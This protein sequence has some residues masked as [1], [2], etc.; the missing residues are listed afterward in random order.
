[1]TMSHKR[2]LGI[3]VLTAAQQR[4]SR[5]FDDFTKVCV[6]FSGGKDSTVLTHLALAEAR[7]RKRKVGVLCVDLEAQYRMTVEHIEDVFASNREYIEPFWVALPLHLRNAVSQIE[8]FWLCWDPAA[9]ERWVREPHPD[10]ITDLDFF[11]F[12]RTG[13]EFEEFVP[14]FARWY[15]ADQKA[16]SLVGIRSDESLNRFRTIA[17]RSKTTHAGL[18][19]TT[20]ADD[21]IYSAFPIYDWRTEDIWTYCAKESVPYNKIYDYMH[22][23]GL[24]IHQQRLCQP[25][26]DDQRKGLWL[27][28]VLEPETWPKIVNRV[29]GANQ[30]ALY[31]RE[32]GSISG[33]GKV[34]KPE[35]LTWRD[36]S[37]LLLDSMPP[38]T[39]EHYK[40][41]IARFLKW[42]EAHGYPTGIPDA[43]PGKIS[44]KDPSWQ[45]I[46]KALLRN[47]YWSK[48]LGF[49]MTKSAAYERYLQVMRQRRSQWGLMI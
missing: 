42:Y 45:R 1:M 32:R 44:D 47:D 49:S 11:P 23:A 16:V 18:Q 8:P 26:G 3:D 30:G 10:S 28:H 19:W 46:C 14:A 22:Q 24:T 6:S 2:S 31:A 35:H 39:A 4:I 37:V 43:S 40:N 7:K 41:K 20:K 27:F 48:S 33:V 12:F 21:N 36:Y 29:V 9:R 15:A 25:Y 13:M 34:T 17:S 5:I 38:H